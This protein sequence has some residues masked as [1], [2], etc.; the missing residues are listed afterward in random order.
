MSITYSTYVQRFADL[1]GTLK[2]DVNPSIL[3]PGAIDYAE[4]R[5]YRE[6]NLI[7]MQVTDATGSLSSDSRTLLLSTTAGT[8]ISVQEVNVLSPSSIATSSQGATRNKLAPA[9]L[10]WVNYLYPSEK[11]SAYSSSAS[12]PSLF[13]IK[14]DTTLIVGPAPDAPYH[15]EVIGTQRPT[16]LSASNSSTFLTRVLPD[17]FVAAT[18]VFACGYVKDKNIGSPLSGDITAASN[19]WEGEYQKLYKSALAEDVRVKYNQTLTAMSQPMP[20]SGG[21]V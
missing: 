6:L 12:I 11:S 1:S 13:A 5:I 2:S 7:T 15:V 17:L 4:Q 14:D 16:P 3:I 8:F 21:P 18:M 20:T 9:A 10:N 19:Y